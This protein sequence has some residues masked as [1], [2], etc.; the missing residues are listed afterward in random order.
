MVKTGTQKRMIT[1]AETT[2]RWLAV[3]CA[4]AACLCGC[5]TRRAPAKPVVSY[6]AAVKPVIPPV[7]SM[8]LEAAP[9]VPVEVL[10]TA[11]QIGPSR[12]Q[13]AKPHLATPPP[14][15]LAGDKKTEL[16]I[17]PE[18]PTEELQAAQAETQ[19]N[20]DMAEKNLAL[21][22][23]KNLNAMQQD[24]A[25]KVRG[26]AESAREAMRNRDWMRARNL[27]SKAEALAEQLV[28]SF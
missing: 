22:Q 14:E 9:E 6:L 28:G 13:P 26:F 25:S 20:L 5:Y 23:G 7:T 4:C 17:A 2:K 11:P 1:Q 21:A 18:V 3:T 27:S 8:E 24:I 12:F 16:T 15:H 19:H 10:P